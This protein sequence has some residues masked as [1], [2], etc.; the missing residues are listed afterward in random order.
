MRDSNKIG[1]EIY[2]VCFNCGKEA[3]TY[4]ENKDKKQME[5]STVHNGKCDVCKKKKLVTEARDF[6]YPI[7]K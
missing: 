1:S 4:P 7:F 6:G 2:W 3:L 5:V